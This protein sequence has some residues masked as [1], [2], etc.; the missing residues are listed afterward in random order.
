MLENLKPISDDNSLRQVIASVFSAEPLVNP[1]RFNKHIEKLEGYQKFEVIKRNALNINI[2]NTNV[3]SNN[4]KTEDSGYRIV[5]FEE[6]RNNKILSVDQKQ[7]GNNKA[8]IYSYQSLKYPKWGEFKKELL[9]D[10]KV[11]SEEDNPFIYAISLN[12]LNEFRWESNKD[13]LIDEIFNREAEFMST[14][15]FNSQNSSFLINTE[16]YNDNFKTIEQLEIIVSKHRNL[17]Q[18]NSQVVFELFSPIKLHHSIIDDKLS[19]YFEDI[20]T[21]LKKTLNILFTEEVKNKIN[22][23]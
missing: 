4:L 2:I 17:I 12:Y 16:D 10:F 19:K 7:L 5:G 11:I 14:K 21:E 8:T 15:F 13:I 6:G 9:N 20:H 3:N 1:A 18:T 23:K 22:F